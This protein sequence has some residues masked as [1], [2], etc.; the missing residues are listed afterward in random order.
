METCLEEKPNPPT[1]HK[2]PEVLR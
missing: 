1:T 2:D